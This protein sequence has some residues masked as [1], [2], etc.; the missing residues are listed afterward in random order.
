MDFPRSLVLKYH[1]VFFDIVL[2]SVELQQ[3][4]LLNDVYACGM[5]RKGRKY[6]NP[7]TA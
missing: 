1:K 6:T 7:F 3:E 2:N 5:T 4:L